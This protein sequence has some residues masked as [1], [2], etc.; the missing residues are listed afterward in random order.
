MTPKD[1]PIKKNYPD[2][3]STQ[4]KKTTSIRNGGNPSTN[5]SKSNERNSLESKSEKTGSNYRKQK[6]YRYGKNHRHSN[7]NKVPVV[8][9]ICPFCSKEIKEPLTSLLEK[10]SRKN[11]HFECIL[12]QIAKIHSL[13]NREKIYYIGSGAFGIIEE[14]RF[15]N[16]IK[17]NIRERIQYIEKP[18]KRI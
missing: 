5:P 1:K 2:V 14:K 16:K 4:K 17:I 7:K 13:D 10:E 8:Y 6:N 15:K 12:S 18:N 11:A 9:E 3:Q